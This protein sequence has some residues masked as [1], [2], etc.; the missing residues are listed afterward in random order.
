[1]NQSQDCIPFTGIPKGNNNLIINHINCSN[2]T[3]S[4]TLYTL[5]GIDKKSIKST[6]ID[7]QQPNPQ[8]TIISTG[9]STST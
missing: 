7:V 2:K 5:N 6:Y 1:M 4:N 8:S 3:P 9:Q